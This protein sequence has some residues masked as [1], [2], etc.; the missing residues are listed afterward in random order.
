MGL[1]ELGRAPIA[2]LALLTAVTAAAIV[3]RPA[4]AAASTTAAEPKHEAR[5][6][7]RDAL[8]KLERSLRERLAMAE[9]ASHPGRA[10][11]SDD[12]ESSRSS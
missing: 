3:P 2:A 11:A 1:H 9:G 7:S 12:L 6:A 8:W 4:G 5:A 10:G